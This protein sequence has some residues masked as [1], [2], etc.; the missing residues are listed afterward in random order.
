MSVE[1]R[2]DRAAHALHGAEERPQSLGRHVGQR[3]GV[4]ARNDEHVALEERLDVEEGDRVLLLR[5]EVG[6]ALT[7]DDG[8]EHTTRHGLAHDAASSAASEP[9]RSAAGGASSRAAAASF[10]NQVR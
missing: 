5:D 10:L 8:A 9:S 3:L 1:R 4:R 7:G 2:L 6:L